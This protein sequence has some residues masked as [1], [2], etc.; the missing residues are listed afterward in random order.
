MI[1]IGSGA[2]AAGLLGAVVLLSGSAVGAPATAGPARAV[3]V[4][5]DPAAEVMIAAGRW[6]L[7]RLPGGAV[8][9]DPHRSG[10]GK[11]QA[12]VERVARALGAELATL[13]E[14]RRCDDVMDPS[15]CRLESAALLAISP[16]R[17]DGDRAQVKVYAWV[18]ED[19]PRAPV[20]QQ[21][22]QLQLRRSG[23]GWEVVGGG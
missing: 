12:V 9:M 5:Q 10:E 22:W 21:S 20:S 13:E 3:A 14:T 17:V 7:D 19:S 6:A 4:V 2:R 15:T 1:G 8:R 11:D 23:S 18:A 16:P